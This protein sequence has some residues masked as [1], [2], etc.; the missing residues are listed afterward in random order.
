[1]AI[2]GFG[3]SDA[4]GLSDAFVDESVMYETPGQPSKHGTQVQPLRSPGGY[5]HFSI[6]I[7]REIA[8]CCHRHHWYSYEELKSVFRELAM[9][10]YRDTGERGFR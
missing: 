6:E 9:A 8:C 1:M 5:R 10:A 2:T 7:L 3:A 4:L